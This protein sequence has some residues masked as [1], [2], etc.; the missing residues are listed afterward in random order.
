M[1][2]MLYSE[3]RGIRRIPPL[4]STETIEYFRT[5]KMPDRFQKTESQ[6]RHEIISNYTG[7]NGGDLFENGCDY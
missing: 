3:S 4:T 5:G 6:I 7:L 2:G 1:K